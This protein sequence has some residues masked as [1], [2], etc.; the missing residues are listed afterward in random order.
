MRGSSFSLASSPAEIH[1]VLF[2]PKWHRKCFARGIRIEKSR[3][4]WIH[5]NLMR[6][7]SFPGLVSSRPGWGKNPSWNFCHSNSYR[8][9]TT[10]N[11]T[12]AA[13]V[14]SSIFSRKLFLVNE[15]AQVSKTYSSSI[16][17]V[18]LQKVVNESKKKIPV[19]ILCAF[20]HFCGAPAG[21]GWLF[22]QR[23]N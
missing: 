18:F 6:Q 11:L 17:C 14:R 20:Y 19:V 8:H 23:C 2:S 9:N 3:G 16:I 15:L 21:H 10:N 13:K 5:V 22:S 1:F 12:H 4:K 7:S